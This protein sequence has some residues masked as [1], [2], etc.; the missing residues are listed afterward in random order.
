MRTIQPTAVGPFFTGKPLT[1]GW[2]PFYSASL[3]RLELGVRVESALARE[4][5]AI[6]AINESEIWLR[7]TQ[8]KVS[9]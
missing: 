5:G 7:A 1:T 6:G 8:A 4:N 2:N 9:R 3:E